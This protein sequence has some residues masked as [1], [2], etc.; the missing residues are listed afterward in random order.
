M[1]G[2][3]TLD[4][5]IRFPQMADKFISVCGS[6]LPLAT[7]LINAAQS[8]IVEDG[9]NKNL[10][11]DKMRS[12]MGLARF[13][14]RLSCTNEKALSILEES[15]KSSLDTDQPQDLENHFINDSRKFEDCFSPY[16][17]H[18]YMRMLINYKMDIP[19]KLTIPH[20]EILLASIS[21]DQFTPPSCIDKVYNSLFDKNIKVRKKQ[22]ETHYGHEAW[23][24]DG[25][26][27][28]E[29]IKNEL[30]D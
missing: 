4:M 3:Q 26:R 2:M 25:E 15:Q 9:I 11:E 6:P 1:G 21:D 29:F 20:S 19:E 18:L 7:K 23:I 5:F 12:R 24:L 13:F 16:S 8:N 22:F 10:P 17:Y 30:I 28:Y 14:F 27:F